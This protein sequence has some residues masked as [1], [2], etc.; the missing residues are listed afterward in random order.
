MTNDTIASI[1]TPHGVGGIA[2]LR[3]S[4]D[5]AVRIANTLANVELKPRKAQ[6]ARIRHE[7][8]TIDEAVVTYYK[9]PQSYTGEDVV[10]IS[11]HGSL[12]VQQELLRACIVLGARL[13][14]PGEYT[15][16]AF[17]NGKMDLAQSEA[18][19]DL[20]DATS[21]AQHRLATNQL[22]GGFSKKLAEIRD[23][24]VY[25]TSMMELELDF[26]DEEVEFADRS[27]LSS[28]VDE[29]RQEISRLV[30]SFKKGNAIKQGI[31]VTIVGRPNV[32]KSTLLNAL[33]NDERAIVSDIPGTTR[34]TI[35]DSVVLGGFT[36]RFIDTAGIRNSSDSIEQAGIE[37]SYRSAE[38]SQVILFVTDDPT[39]QDFHEFSQQCSLSDQKVG[40]IL[41][42]CDQHAY[43][44]IEPDCLILS[45]KTGEG[46]DSLLNCLTDFASITPD[47]TLL[48]NVR[49]HEAMIHILEVLDNVREGILNQLP[50][51]LVV[52]DIREALYHLGLITGQVS[53]DE[54]LKN[55]FSRFCI[56][57]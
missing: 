47:A 48:T 28:I 3:I 38:K 53:N 39:L 33:L 30:D 43:N 17:L 24:F 31:P 49:H 11:C 18:V 21:E 2:V 44:T 10:E 13:A 56:G 50:A 45:A 55:I 4:G 9:S 35:E 27:Q 19:A 25:L 52:I 16:R 15:L 5:E 46:M 12:Y 6:F 42:K 26:S 1:A 41:N 20:I 57:K 29:L 36:F 8:R 51:D 40:K 14:E 22:R 23:R 32:G 37:R 34:D 7:G 54:V